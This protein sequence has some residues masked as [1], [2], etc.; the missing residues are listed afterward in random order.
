M[1]EILLQVEDL[2]VVYGNGHEAVHAV[3]FQLTGGNCCA[4]VGAN[5][6]GKSTVFNAIMGLLP[7]ASGR[8]SLNGAPVA[9]AL[10]HNGL[11]YV[12]QNDHID[13]SFPILVEEVVML[14]R[15]GHMNWRRRPRPEDRAK[16]REAM[17]RLAISPL[18][19]R[20]IGELSGGQRKRVFL[21]RALAQESRVILLDEPFTGVDLQT[22][23]AV[24]DLLGELR[25]AGYLLLV[26]THNLGAVPRFCNE[27]ILLNRTVIAQG[28]VRE[29][30]NLGNLE[31][32]FGSGLKNVGLAGLSIISDD[33]HPA[34]FNEQGHS[35]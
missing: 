31:R 28:P 5:G 24:M 27:T 12:P 23:Y 30:Y 17:E 2:S 15:H 26:S 33:E 3:N 29:I 21:A 11:A 9:T 19:R 13:H 22:E 8:I 6:S 4:L 10:K 7:L 35:L 20:Q 25:R 1:S 34:V 32:A 14:G 16:V 18:A